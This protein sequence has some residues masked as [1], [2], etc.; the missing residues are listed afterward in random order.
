MIEA[1]VLRFPYKRL[2]EQS[3]LSARGTK[4]GGDR[5]LDWYGMMSLFEPRCANRDCQRLLA[6]PKN[7]KEIFRVREVFS[8]GSRDVRA[9]KQLR[10]T[11]LKGFLTVHRQEKRA[12]VRLDQPR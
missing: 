4:V 1:A 12:T 8:V 5:L 9:G 6:N 11:W 7:M 2:Y 10:S 3:K